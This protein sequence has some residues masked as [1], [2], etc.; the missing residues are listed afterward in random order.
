LSEITH[1]ISD[2]HLSHERPDLFA[3]FEQYMQT[4]AIQSDRLYVL[5]DLFE[6]WIGDDCINLTDGSAKLYLDVIALFKDY[7]ENHGELFFMH[8]NRDFLLSKAF[9][10]VTG[11]TLLEEPFCININGHQVAL[12]HGDSLCT[13]DVSYQEFR[14]M[15]R[16]PV[17]QT[18]FLSYPIDKRIEIAMGLRQQSQQA[19]SEKSNEIMDVNPQSVIEFF[20]KYE[21]NTLIHGHTH[22]QATHQLNANNK[23][24]NRVVLSDWGLKGFYLSINGNG[25]P[26]ASDNVEQLAIDETYFN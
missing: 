23:Q 2:L 25:T 11:G 16:N 17:W 12:M 5:G 26:D 15:V 3:L 6:V 4:I 24:V 22:R 8:G 7:S 9:E 19:Q 13:D 18:E 21:V 1:I 10:A 20:E 14:T